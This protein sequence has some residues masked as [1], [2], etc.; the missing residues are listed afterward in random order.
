MDR[1][2]PFIYSD[3]RAT[4]ARAVLRD[5]GLRVLP[6]VD[7]RK[8]LVGVLSRGDIMTITSS[9]SP[10]QVKGIMAKPKFAATTDMDVRYAVQRMIR[11]DEWYAPVVKSSQDYTYAGTFTL[12]NFIS[13][14]LKKDLAALSKPISEVMSTDLITCSPDE[15][16]DNVWRLMQE[17]SFAGLPVVKRGRI[18]GIV[19]QKDLLDSGTILPAFESKKGRF[20]APSKISSV[21]R[22][23]V[24]SLKST[25]TVREAAELMLNKNIGRVPVVDAKGRLIGIVDREDIAKRLI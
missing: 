5:R 21:M 9:V 8:R 13:K 10:I 11:I 16:V 17:R 4:S 25:A 2:Y 1:N 22:T 14:L 18:V 7:G 19:T 15:E 20:K 12:E 23:T 3:E 24:K 6:V